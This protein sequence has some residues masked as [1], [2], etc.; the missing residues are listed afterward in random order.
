MRPRWASL[1]GGFS[2]AV[3][4]RYIDTG[5]ISRWSFEK[6][7]PTSPSSYSA[8]DMTVRTETSVLPPLSNDLLARFQYGWHTLWSFRQVNTPY[9]V[10]NVPR[11]SSLDPH[12]V[13]PRWRFVLQQAVVA[14]TCYLL[15]DLLGQRAPPSNPA[16]LF[17]PALIPIFSRLPEVTLS[18]LKRRALTIAG[19][20][21]TFFFIIQGFQ[22]FAG[23]TGYR[24]WSVASGELAACFWFDSGCV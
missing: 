16:Q 15:L 18:E 3:L 2:V 14:V 20:A 6:K 4:L 22:S 7:R 8:F 12:Y 11:F 21:A 13:P 5:L 19:F 24:S 17:D 23:S 1:L 9:E 10:K